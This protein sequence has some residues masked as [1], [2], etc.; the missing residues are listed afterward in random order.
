M[1]KNQLDDLLNDAYET[2]HLT[3]NCWQVWWLYSGEDTPVEVRMVLESDPSA[4]DIPLYATFTAAIVGVGK[5]YDRSKGV[6]S[7]RR[8]INEAKSRNCISSQT[9]KSLESRLAN[10]EKLA[11][12]VNRIRHT[13]IAHHSLN[14]ASRALL[15]EA[16]VTYGDIEELLEISRGIITDLAMALNI[17]YSLGHPAKAHERMLQNFA[18]LAVQAGVCRPTPEGLSE[19]GEELGVVLGMSFAQA[20]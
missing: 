11:Q 2:L 7:I 20:G 19:V 13:R 6:L 10:G 15:G 17:T 14:R 9:I 5:L 16:K 3:E 18:R 8:L 1:N 12:A 4:F